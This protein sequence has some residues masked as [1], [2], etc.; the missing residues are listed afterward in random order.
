M[1]DPEGSPKS[2]RIRAVQETPPP[3]LFA[4]ETR[5]FHLPDTDVGALF[6]PP[7]YFDKQPTAT[8]LIGDEAFILDPATPSTPKHRQ[9][10][11]QLL[12]GPAAIVLKRHMDA[13]V[14][15][16]CTHSRPNFELPWQLRQQTTSKSTGFAVASSQTGDRWILTNAHSVTYASQV[17]LKRRGDDERHQ[18]Q[19]LSIGTECDVALLSVDDDEFWN[20]VVPL[21]L[22]DD[23]PELQD[24][25]AVL[26]YPI[27]GESLAISAGVVSRVQMTHYS[28]GCMSLLCIQTDAAINSGNSGGPVLNSRGHCI[29]IAFQSLTGDTQ[30]IGY[31]IPTSV[32][33]HFLE[34]YNR[35]DGHYTGFP[36]LN[37]AW[38]E[39]DSKAL[40]RAYGLGPHEKGILVRNIVEAA[41]E[42]RRLQVDDIILCIDGV[43]VGSDGTVPFRHGERVDFKYLITNRFVGENVTLDIMR[44]GKR[45][46]V[47]IPL[48]P[49]QHLIPAHNGEKKPRYFMVGGLVFTS[50]SDQY[51]SQ[52]YGSVNNAPVRLTA[53]SFYGTKSRED[54]EVVVLSNVLACPA[55]VGYDATVG[56]KDAAVSAFN[57]EHVWCL[58][59]L[60]RLVTSCDSDFMRFDM[61]N[62][63]VIVL[64]T[65]AA[66]K[67]TA[68][69]AEE[70]NVAGAMSRDLRRALEGNGVGEH[71]EEAEAAA[72]G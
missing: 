35:T 53:K 68:K 6:S 58:E 44:Q 62:D 63:K 9:C 33:R 37:I 71:L 66:R 46:S 22:S 23:L 18:A 7:R 52:R 34:D 8:D 65:K 59:Q 42:S 60:A 56:L 15:V 29:G 1:S 40:K 61:E 50:C 5:P 69:V 64:E 48:Q 17:Q 31:V 24:A 13:V 49:F 4:G 12:T 14:K 21:E 41:E 26:G 57:G 38:Q 16:Y 47:S 43:K 20:D 27:G 25:V 11:Q 19:V 72:S 3:S 10:E 28:H 32:V 51:L 54:E 39:M 67:C 55:T 30:S 2:P 36:S 70:H 45:M